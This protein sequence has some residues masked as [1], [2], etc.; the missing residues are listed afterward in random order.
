[1]FR[2]AY[3]PR[4]LEEVDD[5]EN[6]FEKLAAGGGAEG[7]YYQTLAGMR[8]DMR[9]S[10]AAPAVMQAAAALRADLQTMPEATSHALLEGDGEEGLK[11]PKNIA[12]TQ[13][14]KGCA[15]RSHTRRICCS[16]RR[17]TRIT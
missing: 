10:A 11:H 14:G 2:E 3:I 12:G 8:P 13:E 4:R 6:D 9:G 17:C 16:P 1:V 5:Y 15:P 7:I